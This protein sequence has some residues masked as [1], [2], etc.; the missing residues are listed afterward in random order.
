MCACCLDNNRCV[1]A[2]GRGTLRSAES[3]VD[4]VDAEDV[5]SVL[6]RSRLF[7]PQPGLLV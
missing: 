7:D 6:L 2:E 4:K 1:Q 3:K 5:L